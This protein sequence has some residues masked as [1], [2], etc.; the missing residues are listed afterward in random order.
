M[1]DLLFAL[2]QFIC[3]VGLL[4]GLI[5]TIVH[6]DCVEEV[7][8][9]YNPMA[10]HYWVPAEYAHQQLFAKDSRVAEPEVEVRPAVHMAQLSDGEHSLAKAI[11]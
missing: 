6:H 4:C 2:G 5:L 8:A 3:A 10:G 9:R 1:F 7:R 11:R